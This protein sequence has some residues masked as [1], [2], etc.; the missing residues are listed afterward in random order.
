MLATN[1]LR[2]LH[3]RG[4]P[5]GATGEALPALVLARRALAARRGARP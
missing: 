4:A 3:R 5:G 2:A 1:S